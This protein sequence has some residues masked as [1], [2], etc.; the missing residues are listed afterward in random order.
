ML[1]FGTPLAFGQNKTNNIFH[2]KFLGIE[3]KTQF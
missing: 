1:F 2:N 3:T